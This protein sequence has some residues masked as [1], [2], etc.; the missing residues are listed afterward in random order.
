MKKKIFHLLLLF[1]VVGLGSLCVFQLFGRGAEATDYSNHDNWL[2]I[3][4]STDMVF[5]V[6]RIL[7]A[8]IF[9]MH[10]YE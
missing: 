8:I 3:P 5:G 9:Q 7:Q 10:N 1:F 6:K 4:A 2:A